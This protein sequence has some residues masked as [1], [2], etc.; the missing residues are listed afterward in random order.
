MQGVDKWGIGQL[1][2]STRFDESFVIS[3]I[4]P[5]GEI[6]FDTKGKPKARSMSYEI[7]YIPNITVS[8]LPSGSEWV[9]VRE[10]FMSNDDIISKELSLHNWVLIKD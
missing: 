4:I 2:G 9:H 5:I 3:D 10:P 8:V 1:F 7:S 6:K